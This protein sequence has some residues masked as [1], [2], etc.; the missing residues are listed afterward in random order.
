MT[1][2]KDWQMGLQENDGRNDSLWQCLGDVL[3]FCLLV[4]QKKMF[5]GR[6]LINYFGRL[7]FQVAKRSQELIPS[8][9]NC[10]QVKVTAYFG[11]AYPDP[12]IYLCKCHNTNQYLLLTFFQNMKTSVF[13]QLVILYLKTR[14]KFKFTK[15]QQK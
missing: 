3:V 15:T 2:W 13:H 5:Q 9:Q 6:G 11:V 14:F 10:S 7:C 12:F 8:A 1:F 4:F